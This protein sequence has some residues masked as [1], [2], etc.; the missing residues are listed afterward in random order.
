[1][2]FC[3]VAFCHE[4]SVARRAALYWGTIPIP[5]P[6]ELDPDSTIA[7]AEAVLLRRKAVSPGDIL[8]IAAGAPG[9]PGQ[10]NLMKLIRV[11]GG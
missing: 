4:E 3:Q 9:Q 5:M 7:Q 10:T 8:A 6:L 1:M 11:G 2:P